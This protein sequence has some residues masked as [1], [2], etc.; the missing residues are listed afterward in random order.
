MN[1]MA[2]S[3]VNAVSE[4]ACHPRRPAGVAHVPAAHAPPVLPGGAVRVQLPGVVASVA[5]AAQVV[6][7]AQAGRKDGIGVEALQLLEGLEAAVDDRPPGAAVRV[8]PEAGQRG[9]GAAHLHLA[10]QHRGEA[11][12]PHVVAQGQL[13]ELERVLVGHR[14]VRGHVAAGVDARPGRPAQRRLA[15]GAGEPDPA[16]GEP[17]D[18]RGLQVRMAVAGQVVPPELV[19][20]DEQDVGR[21]FQFSPS[22]SIPPAQSLRFNP[23]GSTLRRRNPCGGPAADR[24]VLDRLAERRLRVA[25]LSPAPVEQPG[26]GIE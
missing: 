15:V 11:E 9:P 16:G 22:G 23:S 4:C 5:P 7:V 3:V 18:V 20:H 13:P 19:E 6:V 24:Q 14:A 10:D 25:A 8:H 26:A 21:V 1:S 17:V 12:V 2:R